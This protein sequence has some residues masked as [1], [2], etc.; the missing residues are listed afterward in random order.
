MVAPVLELTSKV[1]GVEDLLLGSDPD[2]KSWGSE[3]Q[4]PGGE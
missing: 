1:E 4:A 3:P 2:R